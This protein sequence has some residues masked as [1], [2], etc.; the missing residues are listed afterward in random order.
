VVLAVFVEGSV[1]VGDRL[2]WIRD[3]K[4]GFS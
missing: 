2:F 4:W 1:R 3:G